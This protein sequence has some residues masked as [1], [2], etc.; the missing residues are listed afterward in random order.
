[1]NGTGCQ[2]VGYLKNMMDS[3]GELLNFTWE[4]HQEVNDNWGLIQNDMG[5]W[6]G[7]VGNI[8]NGTYQLSIR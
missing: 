8:F 6:D 7:V 2:S 3:L 1:M 5:G 4:C